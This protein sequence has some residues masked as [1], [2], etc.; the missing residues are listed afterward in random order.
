VTVQVDQGGSDHILTQFIRRN[1]HDAL[2][3][4]RAGRAL[5]LGSW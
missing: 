1:T 5:E 2:E 3:Q 4:L